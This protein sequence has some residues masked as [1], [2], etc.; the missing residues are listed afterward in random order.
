MRLHATQG[1][2][3]LR[4]LT[5]H[6]VQFD[7]FASGCGSCLDGIRTWNGVTCSMCCGQ[8][9]PGTSLA[10]SSWTQ[11]R[12][13]TMD[14]ARGTNGCTTS[15]GWRS[16]GAESM[17][18]G[19]RRWRSLDARCRDPPAAVRPEASP[20]LVWM[21]CSTTSPQGPARPIATAC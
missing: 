1:L 20:S 10:R 18:S 5:L 16:T 4:P 12:S 3:P 19:H 17:E 9:L 15:M 21:R 2:V 8:E 6:A 11:P 7:P 13:W 14:R